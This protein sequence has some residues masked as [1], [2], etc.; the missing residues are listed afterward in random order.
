MPGVTRSSRR[1]AGMLCG[2]NGYAHWKVMQPAR[3]ILLSLAVLLS[4]SGSVSA[5]AP[6]LIRDCTVPVAG[7]RVGF[8]ARHCVG[9]GYD[10]R[11]TLERCP[12][13]GTTNERGDA[14]TA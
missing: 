10:L 11:A 2:P 1:V 12:E 5:F 7:Y 8:A 4:V 6:L 9:C 14:A 13:C 3:L